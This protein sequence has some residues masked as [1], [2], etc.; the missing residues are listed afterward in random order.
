[1][2]LEHY[3]LSAK[4]F[5]I[6]PDPRWLYLSQRH[7][8]GLAH[9]HYG[10]A[11]AGGF[12]QLTGEVGTGKTTLCRMLLR[13]LPDGV[14][15]ALIL[16]PSRSVEELL[17]TLCDEMFVDRTAAGDSVKAL[18]DLIN[19]HLLRAHGRG[20][21]TVLII[22]EAQNLKPDVLEQVR[23]LTNLETNE[24]KLLQIF[25]IGQPELRKV[26]SA[27]N[28]RQLAQ[29]ITA[30]CHLEPLDRA[31][32][33]EY[34]E[35]RLALAGAQQPIF[36]KSALAK[37][38]RVTG[39]I[40]RLI[41]TLCDRSLLGAFALGKT[42]V[43]R[44][45]VARA[46]RE[47]AGTPAARFSAWWAYAGAAAAVAALTVSLAVVQGVD[48]GAYAQSALN[49]LQGARPEQNAPPA[50]NSGTNGA[51]DAD[52][53]T[54]SQNRVNNANDTASARP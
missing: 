28:M 31:E 19:T 8:E 47:L 40:P 43:D 39:G 48:I 14:N 50:S 23:L 18:M 9:L 42:T 15:V 12:V 22:D 7:R 11:E 32:T 45:V 26:L 38:H 36:T 34:V 35:H 41:N 44:N 52:T 33:G 21:R 16:N 37:V 20:V 3:G 10:A 29:R 51:G 49:K 4:P 30:R 13:Q 24:R 25:L 53:G 5:S 2:Y 54:R 1:M 27:H 17:Q 6:A 46:A